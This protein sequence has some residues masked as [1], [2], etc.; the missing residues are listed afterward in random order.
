MS[1]ILDALRK[2]EHERQAQGP[3]EFATVPASTESRGTPRWLWIVAALLAI[4]IAVLLGI[5]LRPDLD[6]EPA[7]GNDTTTRPLP[8]P[9]PVEDNTV[10]FAD[11]VAEASQTLPRQ[12]AAPTQ[13]SAP[14][15]GQTD[16]I[17]EDPGSVGVSD[18]YSTYEEVMAS[19]SVA[20]APLHLDIHVYSETPAD[21]FVFIN[22]A[23][24]REGSRLDE[25]P[26]VSEIRADGVLLEHRGVTFLLTRQ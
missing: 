18:L 20:V 16:S 6:A 15:L 13:D 9:T 8:L 2:S 24:H 1:F 21:R 19:G 3:T 4:N 14:T 5:L 22:M 25:G 17:A 23:K 12:A 7:S 11:R 26:L 10:S